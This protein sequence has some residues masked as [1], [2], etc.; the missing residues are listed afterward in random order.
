M[1]SSPLG[2]GRGVRFAS[3][4]SDDVPAKLLAVSAPCVMLVA[5]EASADGLGADLAIALRA[6]LGPGVRFVGVGGP[7]LAAQGLQARSIRGASP[8]SG[9]STPSRPIPRFCAAPGR[10]PRS[11]LLNAGRGGPDR[12]LGLQPPGRQGVAAGRPDL[13]LIKY[14][15]PQVWAT[16]PGRARTLAGAVDHLLTIHSFDSPHFE[17]RGAD[18]PHSSAIQ[19]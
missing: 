10:R 11:P 2:W 8:S 15:A 13:P 5:V 6:R 3:P 9:S 18:R 4:A 16:R 1:R 12:R 7:K 17:R 19:P 14:V